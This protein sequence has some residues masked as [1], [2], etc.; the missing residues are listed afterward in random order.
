MKLCKDCKHVEYYGYGR[1]P[2]C[3][4]PKA[5]IDPVNGAKDGSCSLM[6]SRNCTIEQCGIDGD[7]FEQAAPK[8]FSDPSPCSI[9]VGDTITFGEGIIRPLSRW[10]RIKAR[11]RKILVT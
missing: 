2:M 10:Q 9:Q 5:P 7:W 11:I 8:Q 4:H 1:Q 3:E 6:R